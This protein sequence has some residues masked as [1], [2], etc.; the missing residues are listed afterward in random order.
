MPRTGFPIPRRM[1]SLDDAIELMEGRGSGEEV[2]A[3]K[4]D[5]MNQ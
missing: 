1:P 2:E 3:M 5:K 4:G